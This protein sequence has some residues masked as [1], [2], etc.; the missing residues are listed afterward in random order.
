LPHPLDTKGAF[1][2]STL[3]SGS[4][5]QVVDGRVDLLFRN[6]WLRPV[7]DP[8]F[9]GTG[10]N[11]VSAAD[12][13]VVINHDDTVRFLPSGVDRTHF[14]TGRLLTL[15]ALNGE[16]DKSFFWNQIGVIIMFGV[17]KIDQVSSLEPENPDPLKLRVMPR[18]IV[19]FHTGVDAS[20]APNTSGK[21]Q[22]V[23]PKGIWNR[24][25]GADLKFPSVFLRVPLF[26]LCND[27]FLFFRCHF[28]KMFLQKVLGLLLCTGGEKRDG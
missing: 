23:C 28:P 18:M 26:Q 2:H 8:P 12:A 10:R 19:F 15:L 25:L 16:I 20:S 27:T 9:V 5:S 7:E 6:V 22:A 1:F 3:H 24:L 14:H 13:P 21:L 11:A 17:F 4:V